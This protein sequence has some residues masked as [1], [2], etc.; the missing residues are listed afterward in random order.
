MAIHDLA[1]SYV[2]L[3]HKIGLHDGNYVDAYFGPEELKPD[4]NAT[5][6]NFSLEEL[7]YEAVEL[8]NNLYEQDAPEERINFL[9]SQLNS[10]QSMINKL[11]G[12]ELSFDDEFEAIY[13]LEPQQYGEYYL[14]LQAGLASAM[15]RIE[16]MFGLSY[17]GSLGERLNEFYR[18]FF[19]PTEEM[20]ITFRH[21]ISRS[22]EKTEQH[23]ELPENEKIELGFVSGKP[24]TGYN[25][26]LGNAQSKFD[27][28]IEAEISLFKAVV[29]ARHEG[30]P[31]HHVFH[32]LQDMLLVQEQGWVE[33]SIY[34]LFSP[35]SVISEGL[36]NY[37]IDL[38]FP[39]SEKVQLLVELAK[40][41][42]IDQILMEKGVEEDQL[43]E[44]LQS[45]YELAKLHNELDYTAIEAGRMVYDGVPDEIIIDRLMATGLVSE[46][47]A[48]Q[49]IS[50]IRTYGTYIVN[51]TLGQDLIAEY[52]NTVLA[53]TFGS[54][55][56]DQSIVE[57]TKWNIYESL[58]IS[59]PLPQ[60][61]EAFVNSCL[62]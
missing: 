61:L 25:Y 8:L 37:G 45:Y 1:E 19:I 39:P 55:M 14:Q 31:G 20:E 22:K 41:S 49:R 60:E 17:E 54:N 44:L 48:K 26:Y 56:M 28:N 27:T 47:R 10:A 36:A 35:M 57:Q 53:R 13:H 12:L 33:L 40:V 42:G 30:Y 59:P 43:P 4:K 32:S 21:A 16:N 23:I 34:P 2:R 3:V 38:A 11:R 58:L 24:W 62:E 51:Y 18:M 7:A 5:K 6:E 9:E 50:F 29:L 15:S 46:K 52:I